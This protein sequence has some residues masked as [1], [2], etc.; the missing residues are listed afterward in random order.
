MYWRAALTGMRF[1]F[2]R[3]VRLSLLVSGIQ[4]FA[5]VAMTLSQLLIGSLSTVVVWSR[6]WELN[7]VPRHGK[8]MFCRKTL[9]T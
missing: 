6:H 1:I 9:S 8:A 3:D 4:F 7:P 2:L 5:S